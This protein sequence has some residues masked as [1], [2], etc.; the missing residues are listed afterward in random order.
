LTA[1]VVRGNPGQ[2]LR[3][4]NCTPNTSQQFRPL[5]WMI[6]NVGIDSRI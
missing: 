3:I 5:P 2:D 6:I 4:L 1:R